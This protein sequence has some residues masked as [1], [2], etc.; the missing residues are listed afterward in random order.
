MTPN[1]PT[2][3]Q[4][5]QAFPKQGALVPFHLLNV[6]TPL[7]LLPTRQRPWQLNPEPRIKGFVP[8]PHWLT[9]TVLAGS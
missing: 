4:H 9:S 3:H 5:P 1:H 2:A 7:N 6:V 8:I